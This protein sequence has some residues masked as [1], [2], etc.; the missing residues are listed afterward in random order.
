MQF[1]FNRPFGDSSLEP[2]SAGKVSLVGTKGGEAM[3]A[4]SFACRE[5]EVDVWH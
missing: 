3:A 1:A 5:F 4:G 2:W